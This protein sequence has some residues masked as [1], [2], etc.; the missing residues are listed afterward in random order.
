VECKTLRESGESIRE[1][2]VAFFAASIDKVETNRRFAESLE[3]DYPIL[4]D[5]SREV[6]RA[7]GVLRGFG[8]YAAR[9]T[10]YIG[11][12]GTIRF[13]DTKVRSRTAGQ[14]VASRLEALGVRRRTGEGEER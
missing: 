10:I 11:E 6:A 5:P 4:S 7:Y 13:I 14:D 8:M 2:D 1:F 9:H 12:D 3:L